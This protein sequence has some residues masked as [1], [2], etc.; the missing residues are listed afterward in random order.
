MIRRHL[1][2]LRVV[3]MTV[4][5]PLTLANVMANLACGWIAPVELTGRAR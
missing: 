2:A 3:L 1:M 5:A 4:D